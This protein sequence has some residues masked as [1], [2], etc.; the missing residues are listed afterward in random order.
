MLIWFC[1]FGVY[2]S[3]MP[4]HWQSS[5]VGAFTTRLNIHLGFL[6]LKLSVFEVASPVDERLF[7]S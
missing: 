2:Y 6:H 4:G 7:I 3:L 1:F 5:S